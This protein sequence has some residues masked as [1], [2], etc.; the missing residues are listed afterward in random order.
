MRSVWSGIVNGAYSLEAVT[1][2][3]TAR[4][5]APCLRPPRLLV[6]PSFDFITGDEFRE[7][8]KADEKELRSAISA[9]AYKTVHVLAGS[10]VEAMLADALAGT[11]FEKRSKKKVTE[12]MLSDLVDGARQEHILSDAIADL[13]SAVREFRNLI[14]PGRVIRLQTRVT[15]DGANIAASL[16]EVIA[17]ELADRRAASYGLTAEQIVTKLESDA[18]K[19]HILPDVLRAASEIEIQRLLI[20]VLPA[21]YAE[22][23]AEGTYQSHLL[24]E[25]LQRA[26]RISFERAPIPIREA[27]SAEF[28]RI[29]KDEGGPIVEM[30]ETAFFRGADLKYL[31]VT[32]RSIVKRHLLGQIGKAPSQ[33]LLDAAT[34]IGGY[35]APAEQDKLVDGAVRYLQAD[36]TRERRDW[37]SEYIVAPVACD[38]CRK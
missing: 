7:S 30:H 14:H 28:V 9:H 36:D 22:A 35:L 37:V 33:P 24:T 29:L 23:D 20:H 2:P 38:S 11:D 32:D 4:A 12:L 16:I 19:L 10:I 17:G 8:L 25:T 26:Y 34:G 18:T 3:E 5:I 31:S 6:V 21:R 13:C 15:A 1:G 27:V